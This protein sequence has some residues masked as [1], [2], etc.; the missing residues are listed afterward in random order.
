MFRKVAA[1]LLLALVFASPLCAA[2][3]AG[4]M[5]ETTSHDFGSLARDAK[6]EFRFVL[7]NI[8]VEDI[9]VSSVRSSCGCTSVRI[10]EPLLKTYEKGAIV[11]K[12][13]TPQF[14]G[15]KSATITVTF[16]KPYY[17]TTQ[18]HVSSYIRSDVVFSPG[19]VQFGTVDRGSET[20]KTVTVTR[21]GRS[22][23]QI[24]DV[25]SAN[26]HLSVKRNRT[27]QGR[28]RVAYQLSVRLDGQVP[29]GY[30]RDHLMLI[31]NDPS[32]P[33]IP[34]AVEGLVQSEI[35]VSPASLFMGVVE[36]GKKVT[37]Q[38]VVRGKTPFRIL[39]VTCDGASFEFDTGGE[40]EAK[41]VHVIPV[42][43]IAGQ[44]PGKVLQTIRIETDLGESAPELSAYAVVAP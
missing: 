15:H 18:L 34:L 28:G 2:D 43:F 1:S 40:A 14:T 33:R 21:T 7:K 5:F 8:Y 3:W 11:A 9:H 22:D 30:L 31:T 38:L 26:P 32:S 29:P 41:L 17:A 27:D 12:I 16:D 24:T 19:S 36:P 20:E 6:A 39:S 35:M 13:N 37:K 25:T 10:E 44:H 42:T 23:W 4:A